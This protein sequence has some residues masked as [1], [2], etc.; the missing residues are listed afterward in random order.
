MISSPLVLSLALLGSSP[1]AVIQEPSGTVKAPLFSE[2]DAKRPIAKI[3]DEV[4][5]LQ[6]LSDA[7]ASAHERLTTAAEAK[8]AKKDF[9][10]V[11]DRP[12][13]VKLITR[14]ASEMGPED[15]AEVKEAIA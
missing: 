15:L 11:L 1:S 13:G 3:G 8:P 6:E 9:R 14:E 12:I 7:L 4:V 5:T 2:Q 10:P